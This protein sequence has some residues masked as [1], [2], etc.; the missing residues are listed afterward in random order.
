M[1]IKNEA[2]RYLGYKGEPDEQ[3][4]ALILRAEKEFRESVS[5]SFCCF[6]GTKTCGRREIEI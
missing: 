5:P 3:T 6:G 2:L 1:D 4:M